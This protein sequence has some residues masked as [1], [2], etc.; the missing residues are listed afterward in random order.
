M[1]QAAEVSIQGEQHICF[2]Y[3]GAR[4]GFKRVDMFL[5]MLNTM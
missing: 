1:R 2:L 3:V 4:L 5:F